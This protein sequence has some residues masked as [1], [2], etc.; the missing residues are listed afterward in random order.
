MQWQFLTQIRD[1]LFPQDR[2]LGA[3]FQE[4]IRRGAL[5]GL[6]IACWMALLAGLLFTAVYGVFLPKHFGRLFPSLAAI[7]VLGLGGVLAS[8]T[9]FGQGNPRAVS[10]ALAAS[11]GTCLIA[12]QLV[13]GSHIYGHFGGLVTILMVMAALGTLQPLWVLYSSVY[14]LALFLSVGLWLDP[15]VGWPPAGTF[16]LPC[17]SL[18]V[19]GMIAVWLSAAL[20]RSR[21]TEFRLR[22][23]LSQAFSDLQQAQAQLL[24]SE[25]AVTQSQ[26]VAALSHELNNPL[27]V[28]AGNLSTQQR[29]SLKLQE[30]LSAE[31]LDRPEVARLLSLNDELNRGSTAAS[32]RMMS[33]LD[34]LREFSHLDKSETQPADLNKELLKALEMVKSEM[35][36]SVNVETHL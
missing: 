16:V 1:L 2:E 9:R 4:E 6:R 36:A 34:R 7:I 27:A 32:Q 8:Y 31:S 22:T 11:I 13:L 17:A 14:F 18:L 21:T 33:L 28:V 10:V 23:Q 30:R 29:L 35:R 24:A 26:V 19:S 5:R 3:S 20:H 15:T 12:S 25:K